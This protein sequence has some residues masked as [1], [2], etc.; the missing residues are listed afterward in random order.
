MDQASPIKRTPL[1]WLSH[2]MDAGNLSF[3]DEDGQPM[4]LAQAYVGPC[5]AHLRDAQDGKEYVHRLP[6]A[7]ELLRPNYQDLLGAN[8]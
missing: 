8:V 3:V 6:D 2:A 4:T 5:W 7:S 1:Q